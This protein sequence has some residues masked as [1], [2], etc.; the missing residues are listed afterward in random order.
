MEENMQFLLPI[1]A[2]SKSSCWYVVKVDQQSSAQ[3]FSLFWE[4]FVFT[5]VVVYLQIY[6][7]YR[8]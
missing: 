5:V 6:Y 1:K 7:L 8:W 3:F 4:Y 2:I